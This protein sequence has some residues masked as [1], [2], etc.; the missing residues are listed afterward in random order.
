MSMFQADD[1]GTYQCIATNEAGT[2]Q[3]EVQLNIRSKLFNI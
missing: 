3:G 1:T 2:D